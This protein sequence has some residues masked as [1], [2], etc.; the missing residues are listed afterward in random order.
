MNFLSGFDKKFG[1]SRLTKSLIQSDSNPS[2]IVVTAMGGHEKDLVCCA[3]IGKK[4]RPK[5]AQMNRF[6]GQ[7]IFSKVR[8]LQIECF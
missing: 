6:I 5:I 3:D 4:Y 8:F 2:V 1:A 7:E